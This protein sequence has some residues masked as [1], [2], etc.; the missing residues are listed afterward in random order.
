[1]TAEINLKE[2]ERRA[3]RSFFQ[4]GLWD[5]YLGLLLLAMGVS[6]WLSDQDISE[7]THFAIYIPLLLLSMVVL[8]AGK[9][10]IT[11][12]RM[13]R[14]KTGPKG[15]AR[16]RKARVLLFF[17][18]VVGLALFLVALAA[19]NHPAGWASLIEYLLPAVWALNMLIVF[20]LGAYF[21]EFNRL[22]L[23]GV[24]YALAVPVDFLVGEL[25]G[26]RLGA[27]AFIVPAL[28]ILL[29]GG[30]VFF[31]FLRDYPLPKSPAAGEALN[32]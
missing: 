7:V 24:L 29:V 23:H 28:V 18:V 31:R 11:V 15:K 17:S 3:W 19:Y 13:G 22:Y 25:T 14:V 1:M 12:P 6:A 20:G 16:K 26:V 32:G 10:F 2:V 8:W 21:L 27:I 30:V 4:D 5:I 9:R